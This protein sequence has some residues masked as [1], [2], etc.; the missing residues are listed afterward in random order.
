M[1]FLFGVDIRV[2][3]LLS[4]DIDVLRNEQIGDSYFYP[5]DS[6]DDL[7]LVIDD[8]KKAITL[9]NN[10]TVPRCVMRLDMSE[11]S[12][13]LSRGAVID[14]DYSPAEFKGYLEKCSA[15]HN[16]RVARLYKCFHDARLESMKGVGI[17]SF[18]NSFKKEE[19]VLTAIRGELNDLLLKKE[20]L[21]RPRE[22]ENI[23]RCI[24]LLA[25][26]SD[27]VIWDHIIRNAEKSARPRAEEVLGRIKEVQPYAASILNL[28]SSA[29]ASSEL[30]KS[31]IAEVKIFLEAVQN[32]ENS[33]GVLPGTREE[34][35]ALL[36]YIRCMIPQKYDL[37]MKKILGS[38]SRV[39]GLLAL[40][41]YQ[42]DKHEQGDPATPE[43]PLYR[44]TTDYTF[45]LRL[46]P[47]I[48][49]HVPPV[50]NLFEDYE[51]RMMHCEE[52]EAC[53][54]VLAAHKESKQ[55]DYDAMSSTQATAELIASF[56]VPTNRIAGLVVGSHSST[57][58]LAEQLPVILN[59]IPDYAQKKYIHF[60]IPIAIPNQ[61]FSHAVPVVILQEQKRIIVLDPKG[62]TLPI[63]SGIGEGTISTQERAVAMLK[64]ALHCEQLKGFT[65]K[66]F[67]FTAIQRDDLN[68]AFYAMLLISGLILHLEKPLKCPDKIRV[69][70]NA[71]LPLRIIGDDIINKLIVIA[72]MA[73]EKHGS[74][75]ARRDISTT[76]YFMPEEAPANTLTR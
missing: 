19:G 40:K 57:W 43:K 70:L 52:A 59:Q 41:N 10:N 50:M 3:V 67:R 45:D 38:H 44:F 6:K 55:K 69:D 46:F 27:T 28:F 62:E 12:H 35:I 2:P 54:T 24:D 39:H 68:C 22:L 65:V 16:G 64:A 63:P 21:F 7:R 49:S 5:E 13:D 48:M 34:Q 53:A 26:L 20:N 1:N 47:L 17:E 71:E 51:C 60:I 61:S 74:R 32:L 56:G 36:D 18:R 76:A 29:E 72:H 9:F 14:T 73:M 37:V 25:R 30:K 58:S 4:L 31:N 66:E 23:T 75:V 33:P 11:I 42:G 15:S 8:D